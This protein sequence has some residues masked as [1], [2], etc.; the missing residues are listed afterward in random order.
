M[1]DMS[2]AARVEKAIDKN[3]TGAMQVYGA[4]G[5]T[6]IAFQNMSEMM[7]FS[8]LLATSGPMIRPAF[9]GNPGACLAITMQAAR[10][11][12]DP[13]AVIQKSYIVKNRAGEEMIA[14]ESQLIHALVNTRAPLITRLQVTYE[15]DGPDLTCTVSGVLKGSESPSIYTSPRVADIGVQ[16]SPLWKSDV[17]QQIHYYSTR[18]WARRFVPEVI[19]GLLTPDEIEAQEQHYGPDNAKDVT[20]RPSR[21]AIEAQVAA[22]EPETTY[23]LADET[24][25]PMVTTPNV[26]EWATE[27]TVRV[28]SRSTEREVA[29]WR[30][31]LEAAQAIAPLLDDADVADKV[32]ALM[33]L[34]E[35][36]IS[37]PVSVAAPAAPEPVP[38]PQPPAPAQ[39]AQPAD[40]IPPA[41]PPTANAA[42]GKAGDGAKT[43]AP[44]PVP[45]APQQAPAPKPMVMPM[46]KAGKPDSAAYLIAM[47]KILG[48]T[49][50]VEEVDSLMAL[51]AP[52]LKSVAAGAS[53][54]IDMKAREARARITGVVQ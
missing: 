41:V 13:I 38:V 23:V 36:V 50:T 7:E 45:A 22:A 42:D 44:S 30:N 34:P 15:G 31:N 53:R 10:W 26:N 48:E 14:Y 20:P 49:E 32:L 24:G 28:G 19:L 9:Q 12:F 3:T 18:A 29:F 25:E 51:E 11:G 40:P 35:P 8:K 37:P 33:N 43:S 54:G 5:S 16:N 6:G 17:R 46:T 4:A 47:T 52:N 27:W 1:N 21:Q 39:P 2:K